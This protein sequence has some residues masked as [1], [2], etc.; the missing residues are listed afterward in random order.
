[1]DTLIRGGRVVDPEREREETLDIEISK[2]KVIKVAKGLRPK[3]GEKVIEAKG[4]I[5]SPGFIDMHC[6]FREPGRED[7]ETLITGS[8]AAVSGGFTTVCLMPNTNPPLDNK[9]AI[10]YIYSRANKI[11]LCNLL[12]I[13]TI[14]KRRKGEELSEMADL[15]KAGAV[16]FSDDGDTVTD[17]NLFRRALEY[18][19]IFKRPIIDHPEDKKL[20]KE[21][22]M[23]EGY[24]STT[25]GLSGIPKEAEE[26]IVFRDLLLSRLTGSRLHLAHLSTEGSVELVREAK[27]KGVKVSCEA[28]IHHLILTE[29]AIKEYG[30]NAKVNPP[31]R[32]R[33][34][35][36]ALKRG[37]IDGTIDALVTDHAPH[38]SEEKETD[39][40]SASFGIIGS[41][42][43]LPLSLSLISKELP[44][45]KLLSKLTSNPAKILGLKGRGI[46]REGNIADITIF[47]PKKRWKVKEEDLKSKSRNTPF[48]G[49]Q[50]KGKVLFTLHNGKIVY[51]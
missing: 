7:E 3:R 18:A 15:A 44:L 46:I 19:K 34:D 29:E 12:P 38:S 16:A 30:T 43:L 17:S 6:H 8:Q 49:W 26:I 4:L 51:S 10:E 1:M 33:K 37:L 2:G 31:L 45:P 40:E 21:G 5:V 27:K 50:M 24:L 14:T 22:V 48:L 39:M 28:T 20:S 32:K 42:T 11:G 36:E 25:L 9:L 41:E 13:G 23:N 35:I 47:D